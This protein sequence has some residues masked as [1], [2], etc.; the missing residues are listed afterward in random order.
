[1]KKEVF[2]LISG[3][4]QKTKKEFIKFPLEYFVLFAGILARSAGISRGSIWYDEAFSYYLAKVPLFELT[5]LASTDIHPPLWELF[6]FP[7]VRIFNQPELALRIPSLLSSI[8]LMAMA[9]IWIKEFHFSRVPQY[10]AVSLVAFLPYQ[11]W[12]AQ[13]GRCYAL[14]SALYLLSC[15]FAYNN[16]HLGTIAAGGLLLYINIAAPFYIIPVMFIIWW[17][18]W[19][20]KK[21][22]FF[23]CIIIMVIYLPWL[24]I[25]TKTISNPT[26]LASFD[27]TKLLQDFYTIFFVNH[28]SLGISATVYLT[29]LITISIGLIGIIIIPRFSKNK[30]EKLKS[31]H[32]ILIFTLIFIP[33]FAMVLISISMTNI[34]FYR[35]LS[36]LAIPVILLLA[37]SLDSVN[38]FKPLMMSVFIIWIILLSINLYHWSPEKKGG[39]LK[40]QVEI[41]EGQWQEGDIFYHATATSLLPFK[42]YTENYFSYLLDEELSISFLSN[43][44]QDAYN[45]Q[46]SPLENLS[47][48]RVWLIWARD[49][50]LPDTVKKR[51]QE[52]T[53]NAVLMGKIDYLQAAPIEIYLLEK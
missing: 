16:K 35:P 24:S 9:W 19:N 53:K 48:N 11:L 32:T 36:P 17:K 43:T 6:L 28:I 50:A 52:Y 7:F 14:F 2:C 51:M 8:F 10:F 45:I 34:L 23:I 41:I 42:I 13:D 31:A 12:M 39:M 15:W 18:N 25:L 44:F 33:L 46:K 1:M 40:Q 3:A 37:F 27:F 4:L 20:N 22:P 29:S 26:N 30:P 47:Y 5:K 21:V 49:P 38:N